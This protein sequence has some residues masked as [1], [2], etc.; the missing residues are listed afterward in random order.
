MQT[1][2]E[3]SPIFVTFTFTDENG[4]PLAPTTADWR[5]DEADGT[6]I[7]DWTAIPSPTDS[8]NI[9]IPG[10]NNVIVDQKHVK[11]VKVIG[12]RVDEGLPGEAHNAIRYNVKNLVG[13]P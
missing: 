2:N 11:E 12:V 10:S 3:K 5:L 6:Q 7:V 1:V 9:T 4:V 8:E 13:S